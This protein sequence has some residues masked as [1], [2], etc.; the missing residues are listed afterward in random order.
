MI[1]NIKLIILLLLL[2]LSLLSFTT[3]EQ[4]TIYSISVTNP[5]VDENAS[6]VT[7]TSL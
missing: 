4:T 1:K 7:V 5:V 6:T 2:P 3:D